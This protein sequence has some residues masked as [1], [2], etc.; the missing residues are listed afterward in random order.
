MLLSLIALCRSTGWEKRQ[1]VNAIESRW[2]YFVS[3]ETLHL[4]LW[5]VSWTK[6]MQQHG[7]SIDRVY[8]HHRKQAV[9]ITIGSKL[10]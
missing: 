1:S 3:F 7:D 2:K 10:F 8:S 4:L 5:Y 9:V 6:T